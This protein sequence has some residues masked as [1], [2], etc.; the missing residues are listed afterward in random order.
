MY[1]KRFRQGR[2]EYAWFPDSN[3]QSPQLGTANPAIILNSAEVRFDGLKDD[4]E[5][6]EDFDR[7]HSLTQIDDQ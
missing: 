1:R 7:E 2:Y 3:G 6:L 4:S 5:L